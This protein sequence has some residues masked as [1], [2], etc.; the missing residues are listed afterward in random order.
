MLISGNT[1]IALTSLLSDGGVTLTGDYQV[2]TCSDPD[3]CLPDV[4]RGTSRDATE[5][6]SGGG[7]PDVDT[8]TNAEE[9]DTIVTTGGGTLAQFIASALGG[10][11][12]DGGGGGGCLI[13]SAA[14]GTPLANELQTIRNMRDT[15]ML[16]TIVGT[17]LSDTYYR[18]SPKLNTTI[19]GSA[20]LTG[21]VRTSIS[22]F[23]FSI[24]HLLLLTLGVIAIAVVMRQRR[25]GSIL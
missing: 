1:Q 10:A 9:Y 25:R 24:Q 18:L 3:T 17:M 5:P 14:Y 12:G 4:A 7:D 6:Y 19:Q 23:L 13:A 15:Y 8:E 22:V 16:N 2:V 20:S 11:V 21:L